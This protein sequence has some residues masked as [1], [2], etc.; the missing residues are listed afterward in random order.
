MARSALIV[1][2]VLL[3]KYIDGLARASECQSQ[4][5][6]CF[7]GSDYGEC[8]ATPFPAAGCAGQCVNDE[9]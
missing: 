1:R 8:S 4:Y 3:T 6:V 5:W 7:S 2:E 9:K